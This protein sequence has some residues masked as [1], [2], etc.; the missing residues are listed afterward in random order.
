MGLFGKKKDKDGDGGDSNRSALF[1]SRKGKAS[2]GGQN[3][4]AAPAANAD[5]YAQPPPSY[6]SPGGQDASYRQEKT[7]A[8]TGPGQG[9]GQQRPGGYGAG[10]GSYGSQ[11]G[12]GNDRFGGGSG[13]APPQRPG[14]YGGL[15]RTASN[16]TMTTDAGRN[17]LFGNAPQRQQAQPPQQQAPGGSG[18]SAAYGGGAAGG[19]GATPGGYGT[20]EDRK[21]TAEEQEEEDIDATK[22]EIKFMKQ[23]DVASTRNALRLAEQALETGRGTLATMASQGERIHKYIDYTERNLDLASIQSDRASGQTKE[24]TR[25]NASM[26]SVVPNPFTGNSK[27]EREMQRKMDEHQNA[28]D[29][30]EATARAKWESGARANEVQRSM[31]TA[32]QQQKNKS[33][34]EERAKYQFESDEE[35]DAMEKEINENLGQLHGMAR[36][37]NQLGRA[38]GEEVDQQNVHITRITGKTDMVDDK[39]ARNR[40]KL[41]RIR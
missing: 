6:S 1:G 5:P 4:Y 38:M 22:Q 21:L 39:I 40:L 3:P 37:L 36:G 18:Q 9:F 28:R 16:D 12:Y 14:G 35:G 20:Y 2:P 11:S 41:D 19:Y 25:V 33:S 15:G 30:R 31:Q 8:V 32:G 27:R 24:L 23:K 26:F 34:L 29:T 17:E 7:P 10:G 13:S